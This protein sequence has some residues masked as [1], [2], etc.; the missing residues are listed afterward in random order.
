VDEHT[1]NFTT[2]KGGKVTLT[3]HIVV[4]K[5]ARRER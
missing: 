3:G 1:L 2:K 5:T 4:S